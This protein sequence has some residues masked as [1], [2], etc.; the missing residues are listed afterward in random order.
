MEFIEPEVKDNPAVFPTAEGQKKLQQLH[1]LPRKER[2]LL[3]RFWTE[4]KVR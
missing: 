3:N 4:I 1:D 2:R